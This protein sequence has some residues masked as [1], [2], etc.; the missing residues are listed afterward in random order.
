M[1]G[2]FFSFTGTNLT[3]TVGDQPV[4]DFRM[5]ERHYFKDKLVRSYDFVLPFCMPGTTNTWEV[6]PYYLFL[7]KYLLFDWLF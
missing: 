3:F 4:K 5:V 1:Y 7:L 6:R 2:R